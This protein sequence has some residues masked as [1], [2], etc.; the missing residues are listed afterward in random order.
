M[1]A[2]RRFMSCEKIVATAELSRLGPPQSLRIP[3]LLV[4]GVIEA[5]L[6]AHFTEC[7]PDYPRDESF[8]RE[9]AATARDPALLARF[10]ERYVNVPDQAEYQKAVQAR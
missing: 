9:Y 8:Q 3:R 7:L 2:K 1:A 5:P 10:V 4:D 6:G